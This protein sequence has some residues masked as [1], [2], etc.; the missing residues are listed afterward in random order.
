VAHHDTHDDHGLSHVATKKVLWTTWIVLMILTV[1]TVLVTKVD[2]GGGGN[3]LVAMVIATIKAGLVC[4]FF[5][6]LRYDKLIHTVVF[7]SALLFAILFVGITLMDT[8]QYQDS[9]IWDPETDIE[10][11]RP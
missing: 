7:L 4:A 9:V 10:S 6:H 3:L 8:G 5:M 2:L 11:A 1:V